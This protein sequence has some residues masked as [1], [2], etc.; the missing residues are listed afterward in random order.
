MIVMNKGVWEKET[1][2]PVKKTVLVSVM[3]DLQSGGQS[4]VSYDS[5]IFCDREK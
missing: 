3:W 2:G 5:E 4:M 1:E